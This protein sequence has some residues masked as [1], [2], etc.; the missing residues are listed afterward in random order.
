LRISGHSIHRFKRMFT[1]RLGQTTVNVRSVPWFLVGASFQPQYAGIVSARQ[2][3][4]SLKSQLQTAAAQPVLAVLHPSFSRVPAFQD[5]PSEPTLPGIARHLGRHTCP[6][7]C[8]RAVILYGKNTDV[9]SCHPNVAKCVALTC[10][11][12]KEDTA[13][14]L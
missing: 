1:A 4:A 6:Q 11:A 14:F 12:G 7:E 5:L 2:N 10:L 8:M 13:L 3:L 9:L